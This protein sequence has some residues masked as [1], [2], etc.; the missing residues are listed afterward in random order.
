MDHAP[1]SEM[2]WGEKPNDKN[3]WLYRG[4]MGSSIYG[5]YSPEAAYEAVF[6]NNPQNSNKSSYHLGY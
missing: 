6:Q 1:K 3:H 4:R 5:Q 2:L